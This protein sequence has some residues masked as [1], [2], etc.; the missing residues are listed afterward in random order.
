MTSPRSLAPGFGAACLALVL[1]AFGQAVT[2]PSV[3]PPTTARVSTSP[4]AGPTTA[5][6]TTASSPSRDEGWRTDIAALV[7]GMAAIHP[8]LTHSVSRAELDAAA[9]ALSATVATATDDELMVG[10]L[11]IVAMVSYAGCDA[12]TGAFVWG[13]GTYPAD[14]LPLRLWLFGD[15]IV[16]VDALPPYEDLIGARIDTIEGRA[17][18]DVFA[19]IDPIVPRDNSQTVRLLMP[20]FV[21]MPQILRGLGLADDGPISLALTPVEGS[22]TTIDVEPIPMAEYNA[23]AGPYG[24]HLPAD[25]KV[26]YLSRID[27]ALWWELL[28]DDET[29]YVQYNRVDRLPATL[30]TDLEGVLDDAS[31]ARIV[32]DL[33]HNF[34]GELSALNAMTPILVAAAKSEPNHLFVLTGRNTFSAGSL[35]AARLERDAQATLVGEPTGGCPTIWSDATDLPLRSS[36]I[37]VSV[38]GDTAVGV[39]P[40]DPRLTVEPTVDA[41]LNVDEWLDGI[42]PA[43]DLFDV[44]AP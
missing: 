1:A 38:A 15:D 20:R 22:A 6:P 9:T 11:R 39:D 5:A 41:A 40:N 7:P 33:R 26:R 28:E 27:D 34:G 3:P 43:L 8:D 4:S 19:A 44:E 30:V 12:H 16:V 14:S 42:D 10:V 23:W 24:L 2:S 32:L 36:G 17:T 29:L 31:V 18:A 13:S 21:L 35:L 37:T 25:P